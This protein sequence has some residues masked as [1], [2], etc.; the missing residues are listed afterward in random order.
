MGAGSKP[1]A[2]ACPKPELSENKPQAAETL[3]SGLL[4][5]GDGF[6]KICEK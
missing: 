2:Q 6:M 3:S 1:A 4:C 5:G